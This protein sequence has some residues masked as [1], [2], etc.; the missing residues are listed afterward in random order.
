MG[1]PKTCSIPNFI[2][3][4]LCHNVRETQ[5]ILDK[6]SFKFFQNYQKNIFNLD[7]F[8]QDQK[9]KF[10]I[11]WYC[12]RTGVAGV[13]TPSPRVIVLS[14]LEFQNIFVDHK[15]IHQLGFVTLT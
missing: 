9:G 8:Y 11:N 1:N 13:L 14:N 7:H 12:P 5:N 2:F 3:L 4:G 15:T 6:T 10:M